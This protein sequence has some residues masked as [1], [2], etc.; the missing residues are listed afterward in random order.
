MKAELRTVN[1]TVEVFVN[2]ERQSRMWGRLSLPGEL[3]AE[4]LDQYLGAGIDVY[5]TDMD[6]DCTLCWDGEDGYDYAP[7]DRHLERIVGR[8]PDIRLILYVGCAGASP[9]RWNARHEDQ[10]PLLSNGDR[11]RIPSFASEP[12]L[13]DSCEAL[14]RFVR[15]YEDSRFAEN[16][17]GYNPIQYSN[18]WHTPT[19]RNHPPLDD[20]SGPMRSHFRA[21]L[22]EKYEGD[23][24][25]LRSAWGERNV[26]FE[27]AAIPS[28]G[29]RLRRGMPPLR[30][31]E[32]DARVF[33]YETCLHEA[34]ER[35]IIAQCRAIKEASREPTLTCLSR[36]ACSDMMLLSEWVDVHHG[37]YIYQ[38]RKILHVNG[39]AKATYRARG[40]LHVCQIDTG[41]HL[42]P[43]TGGDPLG[44]GYIWPGPHRLNE[45]MRESLEML[46]RDV[47]Y[48]IARN[49]Y[50]YWNEGGP[51]WMFPVVCHGTMTWGRF[52]YD[53]PEIKAFIAGM[54]EAVDQIAQAGARSAARV[55]LVT[56]DY[57]DP[58]LP[59]G[60][61]LGRLFN[62]S[63]T[64]RSLARSGM[65]VDDYVLED[66][67]GID[68]SYD[69]YIFPN[70]F[71]V[72]T[73]L[74][75]AIRA[76][77]AADRA[78]AVWLYAPG[79]MDEEGAD[80]ANIETLSG[81]RLS[82]EHRDGPVQVDLPGDDHS[83][84]RDLDGIQGFGSRTMPVSNS[85]SETLKDEG[86][87]P[88][89]E[90][91]DLPAAFHCTDPEAQVLARLEDTGKAAM[92]VKEQ[93]GF[94]SVWI[95][96]PG[97]PW[98][99]YR[100]IGAEAGVHVYCR[101]GDQLMANDR[102]VALYCISGG[103]K[104]IRLPGPRRVRDALDGRPVAEDTAEVR[105]N[106]RAGETRSFLIER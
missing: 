37:P 6:G 100:N 70:A 14:R 97:V 83:C 91:F 8:K 84:L 12:W 79:Y 30:F 27:T 67:E 5:L 39:Y 4:K 85:T 1:G 7:Y 63:S 43:K 55:A 98:Q 105:F 57:L 90:S 82:V 104:T 68:R 49:S 102:F 86:Y 92:A 78:T 15:H 74:R 50:H 46:E 38:D 51:G 18:E 77:L 36:A 26:D 73:R 28:E 42:M 94:R 89:T 99:V 44:I 48:S 106:A 9:Y 64:Q 34:R 35:F 56:A 10:L 16:I 11:L 32:K 20:Y 81:F 25:A 103:G 62:R 54:K 17:I 53:A 33:D 2:G 80:P 40:K 95:A 23:V 87:V 96:A 69:V 45:T 76:R 60:S 65:P 3:A 22:R 93:D 41:T 19:T 52:W 29:R 13:R 61:A 24:G 101:S 31:G 88:Q 66:F 71:Y 75:D 58:Y 47:A 21:W 72:P 59:A